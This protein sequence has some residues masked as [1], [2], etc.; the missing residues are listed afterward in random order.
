MVVAPPDGDSS[1][2]SS[3]LGSTRAAARF[4]AS[5]RRVDAADLAE[6]VFARFAVVAV[7]AVFAAFAVFAVFAV[8]AAPARRTGAFDR[9]V[10]RGRLRVVRLRLAMIS[11]W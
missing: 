4:A 10:F 8:F 7:F 2:S 9:V 3:R 6:V 5:A 1:M 11:A